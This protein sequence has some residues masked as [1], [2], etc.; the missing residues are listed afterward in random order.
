MNDARGTSRKPFTVK[1][2]V[3]P[4]LGNQKCCE[5][6]VPTVVNGVNPRHAF[7]HSKAG[8]RSRRRETRYGLFEHESQGEASP[9]HATP[10]SGHLT[11]MALQRR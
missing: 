8:C 10:Q 4:P 6:G 3:A 11:G 5:C 2:V 7:T 9:V 1:L